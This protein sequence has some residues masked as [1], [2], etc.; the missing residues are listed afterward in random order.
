MIDS[1]GDENYEPYLIPLEGG[2]PEPLAPES[3]VGHRS[4]LVDFDPKTNTAYFGAES[5]QESLITAF[6]VQ[7]ATGE[8]ET[9]GQSQYGAMP[10]AWSPDHSRAFLADFYTAGDGILYEPDGDSRRILYGTPIEER[11][12]GVEYAPSG[13]HSTHC[14]ASAKGLLLASSLF[15]DTGTPG[16]LDLAQ[17]GE[18]EPVA[19]DG[20]RHDGAGELSG[21]AHVEDDRYVVQYNVDGCSWAYEAQLDEA[22][23]RLTVERVLVGEDELAGGVLHG[24]HYDE[25]SGG[26]AL[27]FCTATLPTQLY[28]IDAETAAPAR[29]TR[30]RP[31]GISPELLSG[32]RTRRSSRTTA[33]ASRRG[34]TCRRRSS[35]TSASGRSST[36][37]MEGRRARSVR[38]SPGSR[39]R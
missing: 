14:T 12:E 27:S 31:L 23:R 22:G 28:V 18:I 26:F 10:A 15:E 2:F 1:D 13:I 36:T 37:C 33:S 35:D 17:P 11:E 7:L 9:I 8:V 6:R 32:V 24:L 29:K 21:I 25:G 5:R 20:L 4:H 38:T 19:I 34:S 30:E 16:Y 39:C 3:F